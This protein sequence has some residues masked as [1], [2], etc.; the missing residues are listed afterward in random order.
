MPCFLKISAFISY[1]IDLFKIPFSFTFSPNTSKLST[2]TGLFLS[3]FIYIFVILMFFRSDYYL[4]TNPSVTV[5]VSP[6]QNRKSLYFDQ[7]N[8]EIAFGIFNKNGTMY[9]IDETI[10]K[11]YALIGNF[12]IDGNKSRE[13][14]ENLKKIHKCDSN[15]F[16]LLHINPENLAFDHGYCLDD[17]AFKLEG[18]LTETNTISFYIN[19]EKCKNSTD[20]MLCKSEEDINNYFQYKYLGIIHSEHRVN[21]TNYEKPLSL[22]TREEYFLID[23]KAFKKTTTFLRKI[24][25]VTDTN[26]LFDESGNIDIGYNV[27]KT[28]NDWSAAN[29]DSALIAQFQ[30]L[31]SKELQKTKRVYQNVPALLASLGAIFNVLRFFASILIGFKEKFDIMNSVLKKI[32]CFKDEKDRNAQSAGVQSFQDS[33]DPLN[34]IDYKI[35]NER[36]V[37]RS[38]EISNFKDKIKKTFKGP[39]LKNC[40]IDQKKETKCS[41]QHLEEDTTMNLK[42]CVDLQKTHDLK[43]NF[44]SYLKNK[45]L[46]LL[47]PER[48][49]EEDKIVNELE[50][51]YDNF[52]QIPSILSKLIELE[53]LK[54]ILLTKNQKKM[55]NLL[56]KPQMAFPFYDNF[57]Q[58]NLIKNE[59]NKQKELQEII[60]YYENLCTFHDIDQ[61]DK[62]LMKLLNIKIKK[63]K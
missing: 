16:P 54:E 58:Y 11:L 37:V 29:S 45:I 38:F 27:E 49:N 61:I 13:Y 50:G 52:I 34:I 21:N 19:I 62:K 5:D 3:I 47:S 28:T 7:S 39:K 42:L 41:T 31:A 40:E 12:S 4:K 1:Q 32:I 9:P 8:L 43:I 36:N 24:E 48:L 2:K 46:I 17:K 63:N 18:F 59:A 60:F 33:K 23:A 25:Y 56:N 51:E 57:N 53:N 20:S 30:F 35:E 44:F 6:I 55:F 14:K 22:N 26:F 15:D 10:F